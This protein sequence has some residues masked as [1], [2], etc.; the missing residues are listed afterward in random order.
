MNKK[1]VS[2]LSLLL[3]L[4]GYF[5]VDLLGEDGPMR[6]E[7]RRVTIDPA[8]ETASQAWQG[9]GVLFVVD[10]T[11]PQI[12]MESVASL[13][14]IVGAEAHRNFVDDTTIVSCTIKTTTQHLPVLTH[15]FGHCLGLGHEHHSAGTNMHWIEGDS[16]WSDT[17]TDFDRKNLANL[18][19][20]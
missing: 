5:G 9:N 8:L 6:F 20:E 19:S 14:E 13:G 17:V 2:V 7:Q 10:A 12:T 16:G 1:L 3:S 15:E 4:V 18:Y 11:N